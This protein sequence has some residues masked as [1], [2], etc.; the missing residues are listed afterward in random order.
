MSALPFV[1]F[2]VDDRGAFA[3]LFQQQDAGVADYPVKRRGSLGHVIPF[4]DRSRIGDVHGKALVLGARQGGGG[5][6]GG[7]AVQVAD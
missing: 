3:P 4:R 6:C 2:R 5:L 7:V 1:E